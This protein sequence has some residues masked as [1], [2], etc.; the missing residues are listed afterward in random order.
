MPI[1]APTTSKAPSRRGFTLFEVV[2]TL[3]LMALL[4]GAV[5]PQFF[6]FFEP[7]DRQLQ[8][9]LSRAFRMLRNDAVLKAQSYTFRIDLQNQRFIV[10]EGIP[11][12]NVVMTDRGLD[13]LLRVPEGLLLLN[14]FEANQ[15]GGSFSPPDQVD[16]SILPQ[17]AIMPFSLELELS[18][19]QERR[20]LRNRTLMGKLQLE[21]G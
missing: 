3:A 6:A 18:D 21:E 16:I 13:P 17:G 2:I 8:Q 5:V 9:N 7:P 20:T 19:S 10:F 14:A 11:E 15:N 12:D 4:L 1:S